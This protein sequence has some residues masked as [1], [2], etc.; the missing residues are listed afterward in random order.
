MH[1]E[2]HVCQEPPLRW[3]MPQRVEMPVAQWRHG[4]QALQLLMLQGLMV[5]ACP[6]QLALRR[7]LV[8]WVH[9]LQ[10]LALQQ[11]LMHEC[12]SQ[13]ALRRALVA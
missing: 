4:E 9:M 7:A 12:V 10:L 13:R 8:A 3:A 1:M 6:N 11:L 5:H 2:M